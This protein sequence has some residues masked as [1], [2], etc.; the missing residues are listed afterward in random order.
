MACSD[1]EPD[2]KARV[3]QLA[4]KLGQMNTVT[5]GVGITETA[6]NVPVIFDTPYSRG[7][8][9]AN[10]ADLPKVLAAEVVKEAVKLFPE[11]GRVNFDRFIKA[12]LAK[13]EAV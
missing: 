7:V 1:G 4:E 9:V 2:D 6:G 10:M 12:I 11:K 5:I 13:F 3:R 8:V